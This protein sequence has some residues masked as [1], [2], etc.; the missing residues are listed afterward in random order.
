MQNPTE[1]TPGYRRY[2]LGLMLVCLIVNFI[3]R[4]LPAILLPEIK[5]DLQLSDTE[6]GFIT[7]LA[8]A[9]FYSTVGIFVGRIGDTFSRRNVLATCIALWSLAT[10]ASGAANNFVQMAA[11]RFAVGF[12]EAGLT[13][14][15]H[16]LI[17]D[18]YPPG[19]RATAMG[20]YTAGVP[21][22]LLIAF[23]AGG[24]ITEAFGWRMA[25]FAL[26]LPG[27]LLALVVFLTVKETPRG[28]IDQLVDTGKPP[29]FWQVFKTLI[30]I[31]SFRHCCLGTSF[32]GMVYTCI[33]TWGPSYLSRSFEMSIGEIGAWLA[34]T[35]G[36]GGMLGTMIGGALADK[37]SLKNPRWMGWVPG[38]A[39]AVGTLFG[40]LAFFTYSWWLAIIL[41][42]IP[43]ILLPVHLPVY[44]TIL[45]GLASVRMRSS[46]PAIS[47]F[48]A[49][50]IGLGLGPQLVGVASD[51]VRP[52]AGEESLRYA[53]AIIVP[54][55]GVWAAL[56][57]YWGGKYIAADFAKARERG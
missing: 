2:L 45:Q 38:I 57:F 14:I 9:I 24:W 8:F 21:L 5:K 49:G 33:Q 17:S 11:A 51:L 6:L 27:V 52:F 16:S 30:A 44:G 1:T 4:Q 32:T 47:L 3:D 34:P 55:F 13:P 29:P 54:V 41:I 43:L 15:A 46:F 20:I 28:G 42:A 23:L 22:G 37:L 48:I 12:G 19:K 39:T 25:F 7:G 56:H 26:G 35:T 50:M 53:L 36:F 18:L 40:A 31:P 10:A